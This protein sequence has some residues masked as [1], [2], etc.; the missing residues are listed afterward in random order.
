MI[1]CIYSKKERDKM[2]INKQLNNKDYSDKRRKTSLVLDVETT[3]AT[4]NET[5]IFDIGWAISEPSNQEFVMLRS[6]VVKETFLNMK[7]ME[8]AHYF[9]KYTRYVE[10][11]ASGEMQLVPFN[12]IVE[13]LN[14]DISTYNVNNMYAYNAGFDKGAIEKT[15]EYINPLTTLTYN[16]QCIMSAAAG[17]VMKTKKYIT[18]CIENNWLTETE[19][20]VSTNAQTLWRYISGD[21]DFIEEHTGLEDAIIETKILWH[22]LGRAKRSDFTIGTNNWAS[23]NGLRK[24]LGY[25]L[26]TQ[27]PSQTKK[28]KKPRVWLKLENAKNETIII[29][30]KEI[31][32]IVKGL[33]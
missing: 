29:N 7:L 27:T 26:V 3:L 9:E 2:E 22:V 14:N 11:L 23:V 25:E 1:Y 4:D 19:K 18:T 17:S 13:T 32:I 15:N 24:E 12:K 21:Y 33:D 20:N 31:T 8:R 16:M 28:E 10:K 5:I 30:N 6:F